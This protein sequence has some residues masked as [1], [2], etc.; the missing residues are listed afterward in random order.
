M[1]ACAFVLLH[2]YVWMC[3]CMTVSVPHFWGMYV[4]MYVCE[5]VFFFGFT[6]L[7]VSMYVLYFCIGV[8]IYIYITYETD[9]FAH[10]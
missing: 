6:F 10:N 3:V 7:Y 8:Y 1:Y 9:T 5:Y 4:C 2:F